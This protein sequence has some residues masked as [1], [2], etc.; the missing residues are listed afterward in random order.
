MPIQL[1]YRIATLT[2]ITIFIQALCTSQSLAQPYPSRAIRIVVPFTPGGTTDII[3][4]VVSSRLNEVL[5]VQIIIDNRPGAAGNIGAEIVAK[6]KPDGY[7][8]LMG[9]VG[10]LAVNPALYLKMPYDPQRDFSPIS[11]VTLVPS[12]LVVHPALPVRSVKDLVTLAKS[13][14]NELAYGSTG[15][16]GTPFLAVEYFKVLTKTKILE[17]PYKGAAPL[18]TGLLAGENQLTITGIPALITQVRSNRLRG[19]AVSS[20]KRSSAIPELPTIAESGVT[21]YEATSW[22]GIVAPAHTPNDII[23][24]LHTEIVNGMRHPNASDHLKSQGA[25]P[26]TNSPTQFLTLIKDETT[27]W[28]KVIQATGVKPQ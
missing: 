17:V 14:P 1:N 5:G 9:H 18:T 28:A 23:N 10:T 12:L 7:T 19:I 8:L 4:R 21:G 20:A 25:E 27:R 26:E 16:G 24:R 15:S 3:A 11:L 6:A 13:R 2:L 22:Y